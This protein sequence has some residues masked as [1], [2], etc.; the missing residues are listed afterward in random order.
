VSVGQDKLG[1]V[2]MFKV[3]MVPK[4]VKICKTLRLEVLMVIMPQY[5]CLKTYADPFCARRI[6][7]ASQLTTVL[8]LHSN[9]KKN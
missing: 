7:F 1:A 2:E 4:A 9:I 8:Q 3:L 5:S 6:T